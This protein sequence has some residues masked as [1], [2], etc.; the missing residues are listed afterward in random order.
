MTKEEIKKYKKILEEEKEK[1]EKEIAEHEEL[2]D[3]GVDIDGADEEADEAEEMGNR[4][5]ISQT[6][7]KRLEEISGALRRIEEEK[8]GR[9]IKCGGEISREI[10]NVVPESD[11][12]V[13]CKQLSLGQ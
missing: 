7:K 5:A 10:L 6:L 11:L 9:C 13:K 3:F 1:L 2:V 4:M 12:C 8:Y